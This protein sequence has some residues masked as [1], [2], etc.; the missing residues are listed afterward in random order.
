MRMIGKRLG[1]GKKVNR[2]GNM[3]CV[4]RVSGKN[5]DVD[6]FLK[7]TKQKICKVYYRGMPIFKSKPAG[8]KYRESGINFTVSKA[9]FSNLKGQIKGAIKYLN[10]HNAE[11]KQLSRCPDLDGEMLLDFGVEDRDTY[12]QADLLPSELLKSAG[13][14]NIS[15]SISRYPV[16]K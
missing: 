7:K 5:F 1:K 14:L 11:L 2:G 15:I 13:C 9:D 8:E 12:T 6:K 3:G 16:K 10:K 4:L